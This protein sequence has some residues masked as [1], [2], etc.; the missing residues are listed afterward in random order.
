MRVAVLMVTLTAY[1]DSCFRE[2]SELGNQLLLV[3]PHSMAYAPFDK[4][5]FTSA[6]DRHV[7]TTAPSPNE[8]VPIVEDFAPDVVIMRAWN[9]GATRGHAGHE[10][11]ALR[12]M[13]SSTDW[14][15]G[16]E[17][18]GRSLAAPLV[19]RPA[20]RRRVGAR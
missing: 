17:A 3:H 6:V 15:G 13:F 20:V 5:K 12:V 9:G 11:Q 1:Q 2:L 16:A 7:W 8:L 19:C 4:D 10:G 14:Y 18:V